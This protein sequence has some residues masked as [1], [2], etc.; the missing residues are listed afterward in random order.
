LAPRLARPESPAFATGVFFR[1]LLVVWLCAAALRAQQRV[2]LDA[3]VSEYDGATGE[4][5]ARGH[6]T[7]RNGPTLIRADEIRANTRTGVATA[8]G[9]V[10]L[11]RG[12]MR[13]LA[14]KI[15]YQERDGSFSADRIRLGSAPYFVEGATASGNG[16]DITVN[17]A[18][19]TYG[20]PSP[21]QPTLTADTATYA[22]GRQLSSENSRLGIGHTQPVRL[23]KV[24][25]N[26]AFPLVGYATFN[27]GFRASLG[28]FAEAGLHVPVTPTLRLGA[29]VGLF[30]RRGVMAGPSGSYSNAGAVKNS[31]FGGHFRSGYIKDHGD[32]E[33]DILAR[34]ISPHRAYVEWEHHQIF[35]GQKLTLDAQINWWRDSDVLRDF[36]PRAFLPVQEPDTFVE[37]VYTCGNFMVSAFARLQPNRFHRVQERLPEI[38]FDLL[39]L[40]IAGGFVERFNASAAVLR[41]DPPLEGPRLRSNR[42]DAYYS[43]SRP[44]A[45]ND[46]FTLTP[47]AGGRVTHYANTL[48]AVNDGNYTR[49]LGEIGADT[50]LRATGTFAYRNERWKI[51]GIRHLFMPRLSYRYIPQADRGRARIPRIDRQAFSTYLQPLGL[52][53]VRNIDDLRPTNTLRLGFDNILQTRDPELGTRDLLVINVANDFRFKRAPGERH[54]SEI[55]TDVA[56]MPARWLQLDLYS[57]FSPQSVKVR[58]FNSGVT[59]HDAEIWSVRFSNNFLRAQLH[60]YAI[61]GRLRIN[62]SFTALSRLNYDVRKR[63]FNEQAYGVAQNLGNTW[64][65]SYIVSLYSGRKRESSFGFNLQIDTV[66][67]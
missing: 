46:W 11:T 32:R 6:A 34:P 27:G 25:Q 26:L 14:D 38:R 35:A 17:Q 1:L 41:E 60:D 53:D 29:D 24:Q 58:E 12:P 51:D 19:V 54:V 28:L 43:I 50:V 15:I 16:E 37:S 57:S 61:E 3:D 44:I 40:A 4:T 47:V 62:E 66:R 20:E 56:A 36:R 49:V 21:W 31:E 5:I 33:T 45:P 52:G 23:P 22:P 55:H 13:L 42:L 67:F 65:L 48:G 30:T 8:H 7:L 18:R 9:Q 59:L 39:P 63:R 2:T 64:R 10:V